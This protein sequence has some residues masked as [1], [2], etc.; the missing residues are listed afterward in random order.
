ME[1]IAKENIVRKS[2][3]Q[4][5]L[6]AYFQRLTIAVILANSIALAIVDYSH[7]DSNNN[8]ISK[9]SLRNSIYN[10]SDLVFT[11]YFIAECCCKVIALGFLGNS[12]AYLSDPWNVL[13]FI[14]VVAGYV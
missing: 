10:S 5:V 13:D 8:L 4:L 6:S 9:G 3:H 7:V 11:I 12:P 14:V 2:L 1:I